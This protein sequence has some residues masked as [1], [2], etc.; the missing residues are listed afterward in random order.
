[1]AEEDFAF[2]TKVYDAFSSNDFSYDDVIALM[3]KHPLW[4]NINAAVEQKH[5]TYR[6]N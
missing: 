2:V 3:A 1:M 6:G 4:H 5:L